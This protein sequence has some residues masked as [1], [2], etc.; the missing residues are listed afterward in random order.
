MLYW[1]CRR[2]LKSLQEFLALVRI[3]FSHIVYTRPTQRQHEYEEAREARK[4]I[5]ARRGDVA[6]WCALIGH[7]MIVAYDPYPLGGWT[8]K[9]HL[10]QDIFELRQFRIPNAKAIDALERVIGDYERLKRH[11]FWQMFN[12][13]S[14]LKYVVRR[15]RGGA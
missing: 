5:I 3:Y 9:L 8:G 14:W 10:L 7:S 11:L 12:P 15:A 13:L 4:E 6:H 2:R 1:E